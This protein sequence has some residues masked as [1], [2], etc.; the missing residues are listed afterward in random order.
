MVWLL[1]CLGN[2]PSRDHQVFYL[3][4]MLT[5]YINL[6][7]I[8][9]SIGNLAELW[10]EMVLYRASILPDSIHSFIISLLFSPMAASSIFEVFP[11]ACACSHAD[12]LI[13]SLLNCTFQKSGSLFSV[14]F[15]ISS[16]VESWLYNP[17]NSRGKL[18]NLPRCRSLPRNLHK[19]L[20]RLQCY[21]DP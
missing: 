3:I 4:M 19:N 10:Q 18:H 13:L 5:S 21:L 16:I 14:S 6:K 9:N 17:N 1:D 15:L 20:H 2:E 7:V 11:S 8:I 12:R